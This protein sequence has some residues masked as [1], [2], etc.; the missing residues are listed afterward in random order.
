MDKKQRRRDPCGWWEYVGRTDEVVGGVCRAIIEYAEPLTNGWRRMASSRRCDMMDRAM[1]T[2]GF[3]WALHVGELA[4]RERGIA[5]GA[6]GGV[7]NDGVS[8]RPRGR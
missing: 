1:D 3:V 7:A 4:W 6:R 2:A 8:P 5:L